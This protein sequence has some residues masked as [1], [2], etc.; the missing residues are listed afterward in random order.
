MAERILVVD[1]DPQVREVVGELLTNEGYEVI[2]ATNGREAIELEETEKPHVILLDIKMPD[3]DGIEVC[4]TLRKM[5]KIT[6]PSEF[7][8]SEMKITVGGKG[9]ESHH[10]FQSS[11]KMDTPVVFGDEDVNEDIA[12]Q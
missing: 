11:R 12:F 8:G 3:I 5:F 1:D 9:A 4:N 10:V 6:V 2:L 7:Q